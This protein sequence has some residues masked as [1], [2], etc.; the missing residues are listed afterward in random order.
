M[1]IQE[2]QERREKRQP[3]PGHLPRLERLQAHSAGVRVQR[4]KP[5]LA[6]LHGRQCG[7]ALRAQPLVWLGACK[8]GKEWNL[9][10]QELLVAYQPQ[11]H[12]VSQ[13]QMR[14]AVQ[15]RTILHGL[16]QTTL[17]KCSS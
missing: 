11:M 12:V 16:Q 17:H 4:R 6:Q 2:S 8:W 5:R 14:R 10:L 3:A 7:D 9:L 13:P 15:L 1:R